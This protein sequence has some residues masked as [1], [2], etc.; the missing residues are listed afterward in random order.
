M[1]NSFH[2]INSNLEVLENQKNRNTGTSR[3]PYNPLEDPNFDVNQ[4]EENEITAG[5]MT[6]TKIPKM[7]GRIS[8]HTAADGTPEIRF[9]A[10]RYRDEETGETRDE[11]VVIGIDL[12]YRLD[13]MM[14]I[15][16]KYH[17]YFNRK[18]RLVY[19]PLQHRKEQETREEQEKQSREAEEKEEAKQ[20]TAKRTKASRTNPEERTVDELKA[21][22]LEKEKLLE[23]KTREAE[24]EN[25]KLKLK[26]REINQNLKELE[27]ARE[28]LE[29]IREERLFA[30]D[31][32]VYQHIGLMQSILSKFSYTIDEQA[33]RKPAAQMSLRQIRMVNEILKELKYYFET[34]S[35]ADYLHLAEEPRED[36]LEHHP[37]TT[38]GEMSL[39]LDAYDSVLTAF[40]LDRLYAKD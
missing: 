15:T 39:L 13:G 22:L 19:D 28:E 33:K 20:E 26:E 36:D 5:T 34:S 40:R 11:E 24:K 10:D 4:L 30:I 9:L 14:V 32:R 2:T 37:G 8:N 18:G 17:E 21:S 12:S 29:D 7:P 31:D 35:A 38:Y 27:K 1:P 16:D 25:E 6:L 3:K 23:Q